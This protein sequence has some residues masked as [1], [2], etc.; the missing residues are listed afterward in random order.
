MKLNQDLIHDFGKRLE[1]CDAVL[2]CGIGPYDFKLKDYTKM[3]PS[4]APEIVV[5]EDGSYV[6]KMFSDFDALYEYVV[7]LTGGKVGGTLWV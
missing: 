7:T 2:I 4:L 3:F 5:M 1:G 6:K